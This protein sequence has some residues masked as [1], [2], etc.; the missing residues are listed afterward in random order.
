MLGHL[1]SAPAS[2]DSLLGIPKTRASPRFS[3]LNQPSLWKN[4]PLTLR[5]QCPKEDGDVEAL[6]DVNLLLK[7]LKSEQTDVGQWV[8]VIGYITFLDRVSSN[9]KTTARVGVQALVFWVAQD[10]DLSAYERSML[11]DAEQNAGNLTPKNPAAE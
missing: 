2:A 3:P 9:R 4:V 8:H 7:S 6:V 10:L 1:F 5:H 11:A